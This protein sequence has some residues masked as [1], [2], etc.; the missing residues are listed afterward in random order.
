MGGGSAGILASQSELAAV[1]KKY[2]KTAAQTIF[3]LAFAAWDYSHPKSVRQERIRENADLFDFELPAEDMQTVS[4]MNLDRRTGSNRT[5]LI[6]MRPLPGKAVIVSFSLRTGSKMPGSPGVVFY[7]RI[8]KVVWSMFKTGFEMRGIFMLRVAVVGTGNIAIPAI[9]AYPAFPERCRIVAVVDR[10]TESAYAKKEEF[11]LEDRR[12]IRF[13]QALC[14]RGDID[15]VSIC[16]PPFTHAGMRSTAMRAGMNVILEKPM[17]SSL[18]NAIGFCCTQ[19]TGRI[20]SPV[21]TEPF[22]DT[23]HESQKIA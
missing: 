10:F 2:G 18:G 5:V 7:G 16:T 23:G 14:A 13:H 19:E 6:L 21:A 1:G 11:Q 3:T 22:P 9:R 4:I 8:N 20:L 17:A 12:S 15:L